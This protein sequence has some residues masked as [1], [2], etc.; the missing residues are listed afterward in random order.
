MLSSVWTMNTFP[1]A[2]VSYLAWNWVGVEEEGESVSVFLI[3][4]L[5]SHRS[6]TRSLW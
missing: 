2:L 3:K 1:A 6:L 4:K 5:L